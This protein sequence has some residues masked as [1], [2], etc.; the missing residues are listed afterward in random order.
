VQAALHFE[1]LVEFSES[2]TQQ[3]VRTGIRYVDKTG[4]PNFAVQPF[5]IP[6]R[7]VWILQVK[8]RRR[9]V[10]WKFRPVSAYGSIHEKYPSTIKPMAARATQTRIKD[11]CFTEGG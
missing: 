9:A 7:P 4:D 2:A 6:L 3:G 10:P 8:F 1:I 5:L 11:R